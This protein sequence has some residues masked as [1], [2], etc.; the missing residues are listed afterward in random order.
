MKNC[1]KSGE[2]EI[3]FANVLEKCWHYIFYFNILSEDKS[4]QCYFLL[5]CWQIWV[6]EKIFKSGKSQGKL[7]QK[8]NGHPDNDIQLLLWLSD[9]LFLTVYFL[10]L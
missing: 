10:W 4:Y 3:A 9:N 1:L 6:R 2:N 7:K 5:Y 8:N